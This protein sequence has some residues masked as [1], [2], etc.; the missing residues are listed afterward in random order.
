MKGRFV[1][2]VR[3]VSGS[4]NAYDTKPGPWIKTKNKMKDLIRGNEEIE[5]EYEENG[6]TNTMLI[7]NLIGCS[8]WV[9]DEQ[10]LITEG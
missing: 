10:I 5:I 6:K 2:R 7:S 4:D 3:L 8:V 9:G 1:T